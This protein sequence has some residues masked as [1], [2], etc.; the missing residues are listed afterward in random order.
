MTH[1]VI[2]ANILAD[3]I[4]KPLSPSLLRIR[5]AMRS[6]HFIYGCPV[7]WFE[8]QRGLKAKGAIKK[9]DRFERLF[10]TFIWQDYELK[11]GHLPPIFGCSDENKDYPLLM[12][13]CSLPYL[14]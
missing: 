6:G 12:L 2:D 9:M 10:K 7:V 8:V 4:N 11:D 14:P 1:Y 13:I 5:L 3:C